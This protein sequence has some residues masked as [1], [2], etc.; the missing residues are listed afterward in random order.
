VPF[1]VSTSLSYMLSYMLG[2]IFPMASELQSLGEMDRLRD[3]FLRAS[4]F[5]AA[6]AGLIFIPL[7]ILGDQFLIVWTPSIAPQAA[8][9]L[10][11]L[12]IASYIVVL[13]ASLPNNIMVGLGLMRQFTVYTTIRAAVLAIFC[14]IFIHF[15]GLIGAGW[16][17]LLTTLVDIVYFVIVLR[18]YLQIPLIK[19]LRQAYLKPILLGVGFALLTYL[20]RPYTTSWLGLG[21]AACILVL[22]YV[23]AGFVIGLF[24][25]T[26]KRAIMGLFTLIFRKKK[27]YK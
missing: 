4:R 13:T 7:L 27:K 1:L 3:I 16:A 21:L 23:A 24:G 25:D 18:R 2:F 11:L 19:M 22:I 10:R 26:E 20:A 12:A 9:V 6:L 8:G 17:I 5:I 14:V 15:F